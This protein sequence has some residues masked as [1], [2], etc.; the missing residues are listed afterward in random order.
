MLFTLLD[1]DIPET[2]EFFSHK[3]S[4]WPRRL[5]LVIRRAALPPQLDQH[6]DGDNFLQWRHITITINGLHTKV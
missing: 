4:S 6:M 1:F 3:T 5:T 2:L